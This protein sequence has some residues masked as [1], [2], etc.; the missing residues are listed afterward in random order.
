MNRVV[1]NNTA[2]T[3]DNKYKISF[4]ATWDDST[5]VTGHIF[6]EQEE[7]E[8]MTINDMRRAV[9]EKLHVNTEVE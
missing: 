7:V 4:M 3:D 8:N 9:C 2:R 6:L 1:I 5:H